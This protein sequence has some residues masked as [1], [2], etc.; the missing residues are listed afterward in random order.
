VL[1]ARPRHVAVLAIVAAL[2]ATPARAGA[3]ASLLESSPRPG[4]R[5]ASPP[6]RIVL[7]Y[8][9][10]LNE[11]LTRL[12]LVDAVAGTRVPA[13]AR[14]IDARR[15][16]LVP[17]RRLP[18]GA[19]RL[20]WRSVST[21]DGHVRE[22]SVGFG[23]GADAAG[24]AVRLEQ[25]PLAGLGWARTV[26]RTVLYV[27]LLF[28][29]GGLLA[30][31][32]LGGRRAGQWLMPAS[33]R[34]AVAAAAGDPGGFAG[35]AE[36][37]TARAGWLA[38]GAATAATV[39][40]ALDAVGRIDPSGARDFL[41]TGLAGLSRLA[42]VAL[43]VAAAATCR[44]HL[45]AAAALSAAALLAV[46]LGGHAA[47]AEP[48]ALAVGTDWVHLLAAA[49]W[50]GGIAH[51][52]VAWLPTLRGRDRALRR[53]VLTTV[54]PRF[55]RLA[56]PAFLVVAA[57]GLWNAVIQLGGVEELWQTAYGR[58]LAV[59]VALVAIIALASYLHAFRLRAKVLNPGPAVHEP[60]P[61]A[62]T[63]HRLLGSEPILGVAVVA[64]AALLV[65]FPVPPREAR[66][67][68]EAFAA[69]RAC[70]PCPF[71][72]PVRG[73][74]A[75]AAPA[76][77]LTVAAW[78]RRDGAQLAGTLRVIDRKRQPARARA[79]IVG[80]RGQRACGRGCWRFR[81]DRMPS[82][83]VTVAA[84]EGRQRVRLPARWQSS[85]DE[86]A[87]RLLAESQRA[88]RALPTFRQIEVVRSAGVPG[89]SARTD[90]WFAS[91]DRMA[92]R[93]RSGESVVIGRRSWIRTEGL[94]WAEVTQAEDFRVRHGFRWTVF[95]TTARLLGV[96]REGGRELVDL[97]FVDYGY[98]VW[99]R[100][101]V[102]LR[103]RRTL[104]ATL[105][106]PE[107]RIEDRFLDFRRPVEIRPP[108]PGA[109]TAR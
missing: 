8:T 89:R 58:V 77:R 96:R 9:E 44:R 12:R 30:G 99:Y 20:H 66:E 27:A 61:A 47:A 42:L 26:V 43:L 41:L 63:H 64:A 10:P 75:V 97:A 83:A 80:A 94:P 13:T 65:A 18:Q 100:M 104:R 31:A 17:S 50:L 29:A 87:E 78:L 79:T 4:A 57:T 19:Y 2:A 38:A 6:A 74:L 22:G 101:T 46:A 59:K 56:L 103:T 105:T 40:E 33:A 98:P 93:T 15:L 82:L 52:A 39:L 34:R 106:T 25:G 81:A 5:L 95:A 109:P 37:R 24:G 69:V 68:A 35:T 62:R 45:R 90:F 11:R 92:Y 48:R 102:D 36:R 72:K 86:R 7:A 21:I 67:T 71:A 70:V 84:R 76:G 32:L 85:A 3:H 88:M 53:Q 49:L 51:V 91:P 60:S 1:A 107:N 108:V 23:V 55:G 54:L 14:L 73:E 28:F 16:A